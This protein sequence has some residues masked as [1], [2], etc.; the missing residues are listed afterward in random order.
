MLS[1]WSGPKFC[2]VRE[3]CPFPKQQIF[4]SSKPKEF[5]DDNFKFHEN[6]SK[7][8]KIVEDTVGKGEITHSR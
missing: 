3:G 7:F 4:Y 6:R 5:T 2:S 1:I 8:S